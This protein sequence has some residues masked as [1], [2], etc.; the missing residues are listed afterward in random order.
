MT[1]SG[2]SWQQLHLWNMERKLGQRLQLCLQVYNQFNDWEQ[3]S[4]TFA[5]DRDDSL[6]MVDV[7]GGGGRVMVPGNIMRDP[8]V[9]RLNINLWIFELLLQLKFSLSAGSSSP[10]TSSTSCWPSD[11][12]GCSGTPSLLSTTST[13]LPP[14]GR[15]H[16]FFIWNASLECID[17]AEAKHGCRIY[18]LQCR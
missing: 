3:K 10:Q 1:F 5:R 6:V 2:N 14:A 12:R 11:P 8:R 18:N 13:T 16:P 15:S 7:N 4:W 17:H 9:F